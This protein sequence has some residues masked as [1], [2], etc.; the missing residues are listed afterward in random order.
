ML[1]RKLPRPDGG[2]PLDLGDD[3]VLQS[4]KLRL[5]DQGDLT[6][7]VGEGGTLSGP[8]DTGSGKA[9]DDTE[10]LSTIID[11]IN[12]RFGTE[13]DAQDLVDRVTAD[14]VD[15]AGL[16]QAARANDKGNFAVPFKE[17][18]DD[19]L[20]NRH[21]KHADFINTLFADEALGEFFRAWMLEQVYGRLRGDDRRE[22]LRA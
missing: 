19:A 10:R 16:K 4:Y 20:V 13:F 9:K 1:R 6:L 5:E 3:V 11:V 18:L 7:R 21:E 12:E 2:G 22:R 15:N 8:A 14:L 17:V